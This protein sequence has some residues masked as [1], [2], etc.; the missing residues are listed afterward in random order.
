MYEEGRAR[1]KFEDGA[2]LNPEARF[3]RDLSVALVKKFAKRGT[4]IL[5]PTTATGIRGIRYY[6][7]TRAKNITLLEINEGVS[8]IAGKNL[9]FNKV[10]GNLLNQSIQ[11]FAN[12]AKETFDVIDLDPFGSITPNLYDIMKLV[13]NGTYLFLTATD[14]AVLCGAQEKACLR[15]Y[16]AKPMHNELCHEIGLRI[17]LGYVART[18]AQFNYGVEPILSLSYAHYMRLFLR[19][20]SGADASSNSIK[21]LGYAH[22]C[23]KC[24]FRNI[25]QRTFPRMQECPFCGTFLDTSGKMWAGNMQN[26]E[27]ISRTAKEFGRNSLYDQSGLKMLATIRDECENPLYYSV[28]RLTRKLGIPAVSP[29][30]LIDGLKKADY[31]ATRTHF[32]SSSIKTNADIQTI[33]KILIKL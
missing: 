19:L 25:E 28:P 29:N 16:D 7:E 18:A 11:E 20:K 31:A 3:S 26:K 9:K 21:Q 13:H 6:K 8:K 22:Y 32:D 1:I 24:N 14:T 15:I 30:D 33:N 27:T 12:R 17:L 23:P 5:D 2:F 4:S 10:H